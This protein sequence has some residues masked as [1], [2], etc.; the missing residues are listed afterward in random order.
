GDLA[1]VVARPHGAPRRRPRAT[2]RA[3]AP[4]VHPGDGRRPPRARA[5]LPRGSRAPRREARRQP[6]P[7]PRVADRGRGGDRA[8][9]RRGRH[10]PAHLR[11][12]S[13]T[14]RGAV[15]AR[16]TPPLALRPA[17]RR[18]RPGE[19]AADPPGP[20]LTPTDRASTQTV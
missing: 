12:R 18:R 7:R 13:A 17:P 9:P 8:L 15:D 5:P 14:R 19:R 10:A 3:R 6:R 16:G 2:R 11:R 20:R 4:R 1:V